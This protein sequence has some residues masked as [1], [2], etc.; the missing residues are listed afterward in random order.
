[1]K[2]NSTAEGGTGDD[3]FEGGGGNDTFNGGPGSDTFDGNGGSD[4][5]LYDTTRDVTAAID[6]KPDSGIGCPKKGC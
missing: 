1:M 5:V 2:P 4:T 3:T 6:G